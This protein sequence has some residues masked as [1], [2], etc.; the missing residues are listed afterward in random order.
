MAEFLVYNKTHW[1]ELPSKS[2]PELTGY[3]R[4]RQQIVESNMLGL[5]KTKALM[6]HDAQYNVRYQRGDIVEVRKDGGPRGRL[7]PESFVFIQVSIPFE[8]AKKYMQAHEDSTVLYHRRKYWIDLTGITFDKNKTA[9]LN[10]KHFNERL[11]E[12]I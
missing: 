9:A 6:V 7:E 10:A 5:D 8:E 2:Q 12:R 11:R 4:S 3:Q 1:T